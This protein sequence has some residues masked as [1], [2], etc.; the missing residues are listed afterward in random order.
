MYLVESVLL[1]FSDWMFTVVA[2][3]LAP[4]P[5][6]L[7]PTKGGGG[8]ENRLGGKVFVTVER[9]CLFFATV[10]KTNPFPIDFRVDVV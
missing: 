10:D 2:K 7:E 5:D 1:R 4:D 6:Q 8:A 3:L 9:F